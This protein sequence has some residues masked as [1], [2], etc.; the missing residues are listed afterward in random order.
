MKIPFDASAPL[1]PLDPWNVLVL[2]GNS[3]LLGLVLTWVT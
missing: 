1:L 2:F 3:I